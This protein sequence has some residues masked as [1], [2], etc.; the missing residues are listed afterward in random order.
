MAASAARSKTPSGTAMPAAT[1]VI[2]G[3]LVELLDASRTWFD[4][5]VG[6]DEQVGHDEAVGLD[7]ADGQAEADGHDCGWLIAS[8]VTVPVKEEPS[9]RFQMGLPSA[10]LNGALEPRVATL[11][12]VV[13]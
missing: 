6:H 9:V 2:E 10:M 7:D 5:V 3:P 4:E 11:Q 8:S 12:E 13:L 1:V